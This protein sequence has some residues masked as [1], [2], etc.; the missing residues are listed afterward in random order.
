MRKWTCGSIAPGRTI[1]PLA[2]SVS[3]ASS[4]SF[5][6]AAIR[7]RRTPRLP[8]TGPPASTSVP[9][10][11]ARSNVSGIVVSLKDG[12][13][14]DLAEVD[15]AAAIVVEAQH[16]PAEALGEGERHQFERYGRYQR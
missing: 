15:F 7:P 6:I 8:A 13:A 1:W 11:I 16:G 3:V 14:E 12:A 5:A 4:G 2:S 9:L 10:L